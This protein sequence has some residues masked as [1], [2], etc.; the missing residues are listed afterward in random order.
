MGRKAGFYIKLTI[1]DKAKAIYWILLAG[2]KKDAI[3]GL[4]LYLRDP[5]NTQD[6]N[7]Y[8]VIIILIFFSF[9]IEKKGKEQRNPTGV[10]ILSDK[11]WTRRSI[12][13]LLDIDGS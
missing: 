4:R 2:L 9:S 13:F 12:Q 6:K 1:R 5:V 3:C 10:R 8:P 7:Y 11:H